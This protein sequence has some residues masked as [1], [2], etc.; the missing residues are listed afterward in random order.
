VNERTGGASL[1]VEVTN[2]CTLRCSYCFNDSNNRRY[3]ELAT[4]EIEEILRV[5]RANGV[6]QVVFTGG[7][8]FVRFD[9]EEILGK[10]VR[11]GL[12]FGL[13]TNGYDRDGRA[14]KVLERLNPS[15]V[16]VSLDG[17]EHVFDKM[18]G[19]TGSFS[20]VTDFLR[21]I[22]RLR[23][24]IALQF[25]FA[26][27]AA[28]T[29]V[30]VLGFARSLKSVAVVKVTGMVTL[31]RGA[32]L[33]EIPP[34]VSTWVMDHLLT[35]AGKRYPFKI[36][37]ELV[38]LMKLKAMYSLFREDPLRFRLMVVKPDGYLHPFYGLGVAWNSIHVLQDGLIPPSNWVDASTQAVTLAFHSAAKL[39]KS[40][41]V[42]DFN[43]LLTKSYER[44]SLLDTYRKP[45]Q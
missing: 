1:A 33:P 12:R 9:L 36:V 14:V 28:D 27:N 42:V 5:A 26:A 45:L 44:I 31:G 10:A 34:D 19:I 29:L 3:D 35:K 2:R 39:L 30:W 11:I 43:A 20:L 6:E 8:P 17:P 38:D 25:T 15:F 24:P 37:T 22:D 21:R 4:D 40:Q 7:E 16:Q 23:I 41:K 13:N 18:K 32:S